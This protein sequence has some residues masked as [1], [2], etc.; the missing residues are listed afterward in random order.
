MSAQQTWSGAT[1]IHVSTDSVIEALGC[2]TDFVPRDS[3]IHIRPEHD[4]ATTTDDTRPGIHIGVGQTDKPT[5]YVDG[6]VVA[7]NYDPETGTLI[8]DVDLA[9]G[10]HDFSYTLTDAAGK[11]SEQ[12]C[13]ITISIDTTPLT[14]AIE[15]AIVAGAMDGEL[16]F[17]A[18]A[19]LANGDMAVCWASRDDAGTHDI[20]MQRFDKSGNMVGG[21]IPTNAALQGGANAPVLTELDDGRMVVAWQADGHIVQ[22]IFNP[23]GSKAV[24]AN[25]REYAMGEA[26]A[27]GNSEGLSDMG[28]LGHEGLLLGKL[29]AAGDG[30]A[31][32]RGNEPDCDLV[33]YSD[34]ISYS[35]L[36]DIPQL[37]T[38]YAVAT[39]D[40]APRVDGVA[41][42]D[43]GGA[44]PADYADAGMDFDVI[45]PSAINGADAGLEILLT[46]QQVV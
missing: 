28:A 30:W 31:D 11:E 40:S 8:P 22:T 14:P 26:D 23:D 35:A 21:E 9:D 29:L 42:K 2:H 25:G 15:L 45:A 32:V 39:D 10:V 24:P 18:A 3:M 37:L 34:L 5:L 1:Q 17:P 19:T 38:G 16:D 6:E 20:H 33:D 12:S 13:A 46:N 4:S 7:A 27:S 36:I 43:G 44:I 41:V